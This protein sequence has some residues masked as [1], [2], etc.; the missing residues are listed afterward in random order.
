MTFTLFFGTVFIY[1]YILFNI[2]IP[3]PPLLFLL[4]LFVFLI[5]LFKITNR[6]K[7]NEINTGSD[8]R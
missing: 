3:Y 7:Q 4:P 6:I 1:K 8:L 2:E 5:L